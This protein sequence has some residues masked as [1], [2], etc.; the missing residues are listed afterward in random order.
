[1][2][3]AARGTKCPQTP[4]QTGA[5]YNVRAASRSGSIRRV[6]DGNEIPRR[7]ISAHVEL[8]VRCVAAF[9]A[10]GP[11]HSR[12]GGGAF[13]LVLYGARYVVGRFRRQFPAVTYL[14]VAA[15]DRLYAVELRW[16]PAKVHRV[17]DSWHLSE[18]C[19]GRRRG[20]D[21]GGGIDALDLRLPGGLAV[22]MRALEPRSTETEAVL[23]SIG[24][25]GAHP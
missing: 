18:V 2:P 3:V 21:V 5:I 10:R 19:V 11:D 20:A 13:G 15:D 12:W 7:L 17:I 16:S 1:M 14:A 8:D 23:D 9:K 4:S 22:A 24:D 6:S 25:C